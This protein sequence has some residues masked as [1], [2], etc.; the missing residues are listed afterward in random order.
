MIKEIQETVKPVTKPIT[1]PTPNP[2]TNPVT[3]KPPYP[4]EVIQGKISEWREYLENLQREYGYAS[5]RLD[6]LVKV[7]ALIGKGGDP[8]S[9]VADPGHDQTVQGGQSTQAAQDEITA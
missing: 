1:N 9:P 3:P 2:V 6:E 7:L 5:A 8:K 4:C